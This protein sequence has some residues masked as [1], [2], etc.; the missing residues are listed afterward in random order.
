MNC[1]TSMPLSLRTSFG[2]CSACFA[3]RRPSKRSGGS[4]TWSSTLTR[5]RSSRRIALP[6][7]PGRLRSG[8]A[9]SATEYRGRDAVAGAD[10]LERQLDHREVVSSGPVAGALAPAPHGVG[11]QLGR[12]GAWSSSRPSARD[13]GRRGSPPRGREVAEEADPVR[14]AVGDRELHRAERDLALTGGFVAADHVAH[15]VR[16]E[17]RRGVRVFA[18]QRDARCAGRTRRTR[19]RACRAGR[20]WSARSRAASAGS[21]SPSDSKSM[22]A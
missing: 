15:V 21:G 6:P 19:S 14:V 10:L 11:D 3:A 22:A 1:H 5:T 8:Y 2:A 18:R 12:A 4:T 13:R 17:H 20:S 16:D 7:S 9:L